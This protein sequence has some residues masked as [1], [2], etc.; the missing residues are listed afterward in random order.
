VFKKRFLGLLISLSC[1]VII[2]PTAHAA[3]MADYYFAAEAVSSA[4]AALAAAEDNARYERALEA[5]NI[6]Y[7]NYREAVLVHCVG[8]Q[9]TADQSNDC[10]ENALMQY[11]ANEQLIW[12]NY[13]QALDDLYAAQFA[14]DD[15]CTG[16]SRVRDDL[17]AQGL[18]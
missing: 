10:K 8:N 1:A 18:L 16:L 5:E 11:E 9:L 3:T 13:Y 12:G 2:I 14:Y 7:D 17:I 4:Q 15:A 6:N